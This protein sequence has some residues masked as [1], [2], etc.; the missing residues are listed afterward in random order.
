MVL[1]RCT[2]QI[3]SFL[4]FGLWWTIEKRSRVRW[5]CR[6]SRYHQGRWAVNINWNIS[7]I[8][9]ERDELKT[10]TFP[11]QSPRSLGEPTFKKYWAAFSYNP[12][13]RLES[14]V[15][16]SSLAW[17][18]SRSTDFF[19]LPAVAVGAGADIVPGAVEV[20]ASMAA[21]ALKT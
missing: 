17:T 7:I 15:A 16:K 10:H 11:T 6:R 9:R 3:R 14:A 20:V 21:S 13:P 1:A 5:G 18:L 12:C 2:T 4:G 19:L 8:A